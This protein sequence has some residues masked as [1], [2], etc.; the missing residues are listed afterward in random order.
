MRIETGNTIGE[1]IAV[2]CH[3]S[4]KAWLGMVKIHL[5]KLEEDGIALLKGTCI[6]VLQLDDDMLTIAKIAKGYDIMAN[7][8]LTFVRIDSDNIKLLE[9]HDLLQSIVQ[10][11]FNKGDELEIV[12]VTKKMG[13]T[14]PGSPRPRQTSSASCK[15]S[16]FPYLANYSNQPEQQGKS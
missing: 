1:P 2:L 7:N 6:C 10:D 3:T 5:K 16:K 14:L 11:S 15:H 12:K 9:A 13:E 4:T 8:S